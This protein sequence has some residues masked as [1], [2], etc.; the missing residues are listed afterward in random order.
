MRAFP[1][2]MQLFRAVAVVTWLSAGGALAQEAPA[3]ANDGFQWDVGLQLGY[4]LANDIEGGEHEGIGGRLQLLARFSDYFAV[5]PELAAYT[6]AGSQS[7]IIQRPGGGEDKSSSSG[8]LLQV[9]AVARLGYD[10]GFFRPAVVVGPALT[11]A[12]RRGDVCVFLGLEA[13]IAP[14]R[15]PVVFDVRYFKALTG[16]ETGYPNYLTFG[17]GTRF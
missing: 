14:G 5:G 6:G 2:D 11:A 10:K 1:R 15:L 4:A 17:L 13:A 7:V 12:R 16:S 8:F 3:A 9:M